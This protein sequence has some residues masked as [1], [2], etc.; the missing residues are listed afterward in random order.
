MNVFIS[1]LQA[2]AVNNDIAINEESV[3]KLKKHLDVIVTSLPEDLQTVLKSWQI[4][5]TSGSS[6][7]MCTQVLSGVTG[8][9]WIGPDSESA[10][11]EVN[12]EP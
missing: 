4:G 11:A 8:V 12:T 5:S 7:C 3:H 2:F 1:Y 6:W 9:S 10:A